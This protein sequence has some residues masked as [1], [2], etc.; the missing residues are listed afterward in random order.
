VV[1]TH[2]KNPWG[3]SFGPTTPLWTANEGSGTSTLYTGGTP[4]APGASIV[5]LVVTI[6]GGAAS[7]QGHPTGTVFNSTTAFPMPDGTQSRFLFDDLLGQLSA[8]APG[9]TEAKVVAT[10]P[11]AQFTGLTLAQTKRGPRLYAADA[12]GSVRIFDGAFKEIGRLRSPG[13]PA[14][15]VPY[16]VQTLG[17]RLYV[18]YFDPRSLDPSQHVDVKGAVDMYR[19]NGTFVRHLVVGG[20][21]NAPWGLAIAPRHWGELSRRL[22]VGNVL[23]GRINA[24]NPRTGRFEGALLKSDGTPFAEP[25]LWGIAF[26]NGVIGTPNTLIAVAG[27]DNYEHGLVAAITPASGR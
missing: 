14:G 22:L 5:P 1:D 25:G 27:I 15:L 21:L 17:D 8:W 12:T 4:T 10:V 11:G 2:L 13:L 6:P 20:R 7:P 16:N 18:T 23:D 9:T 26:G 19:L 24:Y 3:V